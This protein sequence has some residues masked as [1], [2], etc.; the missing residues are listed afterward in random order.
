MKVKEWGTFILGLVSLGCVNAIAFVFDGG[1]IDTAIALD[2]AFIGAL[3]A[4]Y[5][6]DK[7]S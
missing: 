5:L 6:G 3:I 1:W 4:K 7:K 2:S